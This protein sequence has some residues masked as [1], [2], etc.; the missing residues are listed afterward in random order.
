MDSS[1]TWLTVRVGVHI[2]RCSQWPDRVRV[3]AKERGALLFSFQRKLVSVPLYK[4]NWR[5][6]EEVWYNEQARAAPVELG[7]LLKRSEN[8]RLDLKV[9]CLR[10]RA[11]QH[12]AVGSFT[13]LLQQVRGDELRLSL[14][15]PGCP[16][17][18]QGVF[19]AQF[20]AA[21]AR[22]AAAFF[23]HHR[24]A[25]TVKQVAEVRPDT[26]ITLSTVG[27]GESAAS[28]PL[29]TP[30]APSFQEDA[31]T[32]PEVFNTPPMDPSPPPLTPPS[33][34]LI[35][36]MDSGSVFAELLAEQEGEAAE[37]KTA[38]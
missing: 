28:P 10:G 35:R 38:A 37:R 9:Y 26:G 4:T 25:Q 20:R 36:F 29:E 1:I 5:P 34:R 13:R 7:K 33:L 2:P 8:Q 32:S 27:H 3:T 22:A 31:Q 21:H 19:P 17:H 12:K 14:H 6:Q 11:V 24:A 15:Y 30:T 16:L 18:P 23:R